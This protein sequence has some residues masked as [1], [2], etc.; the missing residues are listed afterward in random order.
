MKNSFLFLASAAAFVAVGCNKLPVTAPQVGGSEGEVCELKLS[1]DGGL[2]TKVTGE[3]LANENKI[4]NVQI[5]VFRAGSDDSGS[6][7]DACLAEGFGGTELNG[8]KTYSAASLKCTVG[9]RHI[10]VIVNAD[11]NYTADGSVGTVADLL[12]KTMKLSG[13]RADKLLMIGG[14]RDVTL[15]SGTQSQGIKVR[16]ACASV[17]LQSIKNEMQSAVYQKTGSFKIKD[18]YLTNVP[19][20]INFGQTAPASSLK[21]DGS[22]YARM[23]AETDS[24][25]KAL[26][27][28]GGSQ[29]GT[30]LEYGKTYTNAHTFYTFPNDCGDVIGGTWSPRATR[31]VIAA[32][33]SDG[34]NWH[35]CYYPITLYNSGS[36][37]EANKQYKVN[38]TINR[39]GSDNPDKPVEFR[40]LTCTITVEDWAEGT[41]YTETI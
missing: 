32:T 13:M 6:V 29:S 27:Y 3:V 35:D 37:L 25:K 21:D 16:R 38:L 8:D 12:A 17:I 14:A 28:D 26:I 20:I 33:Y 31:L 4:R 39:P 2:A 15:D 23:G 19:A 24:N 22:W 10:Y 5:F 34:R 9:K 7:L 1:L 40:D 41:S 36:G 18:I 30:V 11:V